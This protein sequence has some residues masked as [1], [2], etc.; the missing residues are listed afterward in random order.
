MAIYYIDSVNGSNSNSGTSEGAA[1]QSVSVV[2][3]LNLKAGDSILLARGSVF[4]ETLTMTKSG[5][6][7]APINIGAY[8]QGEA[9]KMSGPIGILATKTSYIEVSD[10]TFEG[11]TGAAIYGGS[12]RYWNIHDVTVSNTGLLTNMGSIFFKSATGITVSDSKFENMTGDGVFVEGVNGLVVKNNTFTGLGGHT[13]DGIQVTNG[14]NI[15]LTGNVIDMTTSPDSSKGG[16][17]TNNVQNIVISNNEINGGGFG[18]SVNGQNIKIDGN[19]ISHADKYDWSAGVLIGGAWDLS[20]YTITNNTIVDSR[21]GV[22]ITGLRADQVTRTDMNVSDNTFINLEKFA[23]KIDKPT[24]GTFENNVL[25]NAEMSLIRGEG[26]NLNYNVSAGNIV[27]TV[28]QAI[29]LKLIPGHVDAPVKSAPVVNAPVDHTPVD[30]APDDVAPVETA[31]V[32]TPPVVMAPV[33]V[34][35]VVTAPLEAEP[36]VTQPV[37]T[38]PVVTAPTPVETAP[39]P[40]PAPT[41]P[42]VTAPVE[43]IKVPTTRATNVGPEAQLDKAFLLASSNKVS[44]NVLANDCDANGDTLYVRSVAGAKMATGGIDLTGKYGTLHVEENG[45]YTYMLSAKGYAAINGNASAV[46]KFAYKMS[47]TFATDSAKLIIDL[48]DFALNNHCDLVSM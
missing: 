8:G 46:E 10:L 43:S 38:E 41:Q 19:T 36:G 39:T 6:E 13:A 35:P 2:A 30:H 40:T 34:E 7:A 17:V 23:L 26:A 11:T 3:G 27:L 47:D 29:A 31:P 4:T 44:G 1:F 24:T 45:D 18:M 48:S 16:I 37:D 32:V 12:S 28:E 20:N 42:L 25:I 22:S 5:T 15:V 9:P 14:S 33:V 21:Y